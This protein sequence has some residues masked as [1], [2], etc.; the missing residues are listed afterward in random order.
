MQPL[1]LGA[2]RRCLD[3]F[4]GFSVYGAFGE[5]ETARTARS[6]TSSGHGQVLH[7]VRRPPS[8]VAL[9]LPRRHVDHVVHGA[10][11]WERRPL[12]AARTARLHFGQLEQVNSTAVA[13]VS[14][15]SR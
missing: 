14:S 15:G 8:H 9:P 4:G 6:I 10:L 7:V 12:G 5:D 11:E 13:A 3:V 2:V 1:R